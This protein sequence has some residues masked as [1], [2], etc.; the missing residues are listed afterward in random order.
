MDQAEFYFSP[1]P[2]EPAKPLTKI[3]SGG[4]LSRLM[5]ALK[6]LVLTPGIVSTLLFDEVDAGIGG[7]VADVPAYLRPRGRRARSHATRTGTEIRFVTISVCRALA[8]RR[9]DV[10]VAVSVS[11][12]RLCLKSARIGPARSARPLSRAALPLAARRAIDWKH[13][14]LA[15]VADVT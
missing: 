13:S 1:N 2:G 8:P 9:S 3:A 7:R 6:A 10:F 14:R 5:L 15:V 12:V 11:G 4:E